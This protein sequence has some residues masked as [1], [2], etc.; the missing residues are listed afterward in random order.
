MW[1]KSDPTT[2]TST[3]TAS[4]TPTLDEVFTHIVSGP[5]HMFESPRVHPQTVMLKGE[6]DAERRL[7]ESISHKEFEATVFES[8]SHPLQRIAHGRVG[9]GH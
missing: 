7:V 1:P 4:G 8:A 5:T 9:G 6:F 2:L 3:D